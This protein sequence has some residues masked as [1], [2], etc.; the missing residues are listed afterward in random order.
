MISI[1]VEDKEELIE[2]LQLIELNSGLLWR[3]GGETPTDKEI[4]EKQPWSFPA[5]LFYDNGLA[6]DDDNGL[7]YKYSVDDIKNMQKN[8]Q[9]TFFRY[10]EGKANIK[11]ATKTGFVRAFKIKNREVSSLFLEIIENN[12]DL[13]W[14]GCNATP[15]TLSSTKY[16][17]FYV[18]G[19]LGLYRS[20]NDY[21]ENYS[22]EAAELCDQELINII[23]SLQ[24]VTNVSDVCHV[25]ERIIVS[26]ET[27]LKKVL[28]ELEKLTNIKFEIGGFVPSQ[29]C[30]VYEIDGVLKCT[31]SNTNKNSALYISYSDFNKLCISDKIKLFYQMI[32]SKPPQESEVEEEVVVEEEAEVE[33]ID[34]SENSE[35]KDTIDTII[36]KNSNELYSFENELYSLNIDIECDKITQFPCLLKIVRGVGFEFIKESNSNIS[37]SKNCISYR[38]FSQYFDR[39]TMA[40]KIKFI[41]L[42]TDDYDVFDDN[43]CTQEIED[44]PP[45]IDN[46][47]IFSDDENTDCDDTDY[48][49]DNNE[50]NIASGSIFNT[51][52]IIGLGGLGLASIGYW[53]KIKNKK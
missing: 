27:E 48:D 15:T 29:T 46:D 52:L 17:C 41:Y 38:D 11:E 51:S 25:T 32:G 45:D 13:K 2:A 23:N 43:Y 18:V 3:A 50:D 31:P 42:V 4:M 47:D 14:R 20:E 9:N 37:I 53:Y 36:F 49:E 22:L 28:D 21:L 24:N 35:N 30:S 19:N 33:D 34:N 26:D 40:D 16:P 5:S 8:V 44:N 1:R 7:P 6:W 12:T 39:L 10:L